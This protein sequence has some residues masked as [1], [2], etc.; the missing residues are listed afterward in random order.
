MAQCGKLHAM[1]NAKIAAIFD[2]VADLLE[3]QDANPFRVRAY[4]KG[5]RTIRDLAEPVT[6]IIADPER[7][8]TDIDGIGKDL[9]AKCVTLL[10][11]EQLPLLDELLADIPAVGLGAV[12]RSGTRAE[13]GGGR[14]P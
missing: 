8:L 5:A 2:E 1:N 4:R 13:E 6:A 12:A 10:E 14:V 7:D 3:F 9:A 11:T